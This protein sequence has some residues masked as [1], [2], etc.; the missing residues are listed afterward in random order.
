MVRWSKLE[1]KVHWITSKMMKM[2]KIE[3]N[4]I[5]F[6]KKK[7]K[8][9]GP[10][11]NIVFQK[12]GREK[13]IRKVDKKKKKSIRIWKMATTYTLNTPIRMIFGCLETMLLFCHT[14][15]IRTEN[16]TKATSQYVMW[17]DVKKE[18]HSTEIAICDV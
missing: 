11:N 10:K 5:R 17:C 1:K 12:K 18:R 7:P 13:K 14:C 4:N 2:L 8:T 6:A 9:N 15:Q 3:W 16:W